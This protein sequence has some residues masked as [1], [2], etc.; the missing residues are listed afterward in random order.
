MV[1]GLIS[2]LEQGGDS[3]LFYVQVK[4]DSQRI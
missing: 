3:H 4:E 2:D 1:S